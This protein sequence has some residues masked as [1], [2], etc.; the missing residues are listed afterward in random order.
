MDDVRVVLEAEVARF[1][2]WADAYPVAERSGEWE[3]DYA[4]W[5]RLY[6]AFTAFVTATTCLH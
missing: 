6:E 3:S 1:Q 4:D 5:G 2:M